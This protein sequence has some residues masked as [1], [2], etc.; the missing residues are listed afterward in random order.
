MVRV[1][2]AVDRE[3]MGEEMRVSSS[4]EKPGRFWREHHELR[5]RRNPWPFSKVALV[6]AKVRL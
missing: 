2:D 6:A 4:A 5:L 1:G 3:V